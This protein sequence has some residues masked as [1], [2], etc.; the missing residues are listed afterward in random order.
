M[1]TDKTD[2][3]LNTS[4]VAKLYRVT[5]RTVQNWLLLEAPPPSEKWGGRWVFSRKRLLKW[6]KPPAP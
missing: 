4:E 1:I 6:K 5:E 3:L 2:D